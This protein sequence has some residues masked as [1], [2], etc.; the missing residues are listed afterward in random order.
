MARTGETSV[1]FRLVWEGESDGNISEKER[2]QKRRGVWEKKKMKQ[3]V[4]IGK[5]SYGM[6]Q[7][8]I[9]VLSVV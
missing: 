5:M 4:E 2:R 3:T 7:S 6:V 8:N 9:Q 1:E